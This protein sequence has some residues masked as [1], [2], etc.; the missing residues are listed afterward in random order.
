MFIIVQRIS[1]KQATSSN[2]IVLLKSCVSVCQQLSTS[3]CC[4]E[5]VEAIVI[6]KA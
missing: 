1:K 4:I 3:F 5:K 2:I 6:I